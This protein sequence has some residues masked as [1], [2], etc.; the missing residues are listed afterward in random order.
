MSWNK[1]KIPDFCNCPETPLVS[2][3]EPII[4]CK[5]KYIDDELPF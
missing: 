2:V 1:I 3:F 5:K 4:G